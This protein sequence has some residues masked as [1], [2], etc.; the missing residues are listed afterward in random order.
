MILL[1]GAS[2]YIGSAFAREMERRSLDWA[3]VKHGDCH[4]GMS[5]SNKVRLVINCAAFIPKESVALCD[6]HPFETIHGNFL[7]PEML[8]LVCMKH[9]VTFAHISTGCLWNDGEGH[10]EEDP[11]QRYFTGHCGFYI[12]TKVLAERVVQQNPRSYIWRVRLPFDE[13]DNERN[14]LSK[15]ARYDEIWDCSN[16]IAHRADFAKA[17]LDLWK[18]EAP[19]GIYHVMNPGTIKAS[20]L[21]DELFSRGIRKTPAR[22]VPSLTGNCPVSVRKAL[23]LGVKIRPVEEAITESLNHWTIQ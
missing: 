12:G 8:S 14:Y 6:K 5:I 13:F 19:Y 10:F 4:Q 1:I 23:K 15:L 20:C 3:A 9:H 17:C 22:I 18:I 16:T 7:F 11:P 21:A 2:G